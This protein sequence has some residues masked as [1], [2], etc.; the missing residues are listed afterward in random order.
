MWRS[1]IIFRQDLSDIAFIFLKYA[2]LSSVDIVNGFC[3]HKAQV[4]MIDA[5]QKIANSPARTLEWPTLLRVLFIN[6]PLFHWDPAVIALGWPEITR[7]WN[8]SRDNDLLQ[9]HP[10][11]DHPYF[12][13]MV[14][15]FRYQMR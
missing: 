14:S 11:V 8:A 10:R 4:L 12:Q 3:A 2:A 9:H 6:L 13:Q 1:S 5:A 15:R 7:S